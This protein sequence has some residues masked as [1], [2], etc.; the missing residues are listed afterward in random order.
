MKKIIY[1]LAF[2][3]CSLNISAQSLTVFNIDTSSFPTIKAKFYAFDASGNQI[4]NLSM[5]DFQVTENGQIRTVTN[6]SCPSPKPPLAISSVLVMDVS[7][8]MCGNGLDMAKAAAN[9]W[10][11]MLPLGNSECAITSFS[12]GN[13][14]NKD[15][16]TD[17]TK[18]VNGINS[19]VCMNGTDYNAAMID[20]PAGGIL[21]AKTG[22]H[23]RIIVFLSDGGANF[24]P[25]TAQIVSQA[26]DNNISIYCVTIN[27]PSPQCMK[28]FA[29]QT[30][31]LY[32]EKI[33]TIKE[34]EDCYRLILQIAQGGDP[35]SIEWQS[36]INCTGGLVNI[37][38]KLIT[39]NINTTAGY[40]APISSIAFL[41][42]KPLGVFFK[43]KPI[44]IPA[45]TNIII[46]ARNADFNITNIISSD[47]NF[48]I[49]PKSFTIQ[50]GQSQTVTLRYI[51]PDSN[52]YFSTFSIENDLC[53]NKIYAVGGF[54]KN[55]T[56]A[57]PTLN[58]THPNGGEIFAIGSDTVITWEGVLPSDIVKL[59]YSTDD[60]INWNLI[61][62]TASG[63]K[64]IWK[65]IPK[66]SSNQCIVRVNQIINN[67]KPGTLQFTLKG[68]TSN[69]YNLSW[70][71][72]GSRVATA[73]NDATAIIWNA[74]T[75]TKL[76][77]LG[78]QSTVYN[79]C[80]D[81]NSTHVATSSIDETAI[82][83]DSNTGINIH[84]LRGHTSI[85]QNV[86]WSPDGT[87]VATASWDKT[88]IIWDASTGANL[89]TLI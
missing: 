29:N 60:G 5:S 52:R 61:T 28:D 79:I 64:Y 57:K 47:P 67:E 56:T 26:N 83:W 18:L 17:K 71:P 25:N 77:T 7:G 66:P 37:D 13:Y 39:Y 35:C 88:S 72:D 80:W 50:K 75:G 3:W 8:S 68:H 81:P 73:S 63:L 2:V 89:H 58:V 33:S 11:N 78:M 43:N 4:T 55:S 10:I 59:E 38:C 76:H 15:F 54:I 49:N 44:G 9:A 24:Q 70:S 53:L 40:Q 87:R 62:D 41:D 82:I 30:G 51:Q 19:L 34:A 14:I 86:D 21:I 36:G 85:V 42:I 74:S 23:K 1:L 6:V 22:K 69:I 20:P 12:D 48:D 27:M 31:G 32:F 16:T 45:D 84:T 65:N 46:T